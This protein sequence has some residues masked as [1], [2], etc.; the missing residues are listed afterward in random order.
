MLRVITKTCRR[1]SMKPVGPLL[2]CASER[3]KKQT[4]NSAGKNE[5][6]L[7]QHQPVLLR[8]VRILPPVRKVTLTGTTD[9]W[10]SQSGATYA[11]GEERKVGI[12]RQRPASPPSPPWLP[13]E[14]KESA[15]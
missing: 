6:T 13:R 9:L 5:N 3:A 14:E 2:L 10:T 7:P 15:L 4:K 11:G 1:L 8:C 12:K